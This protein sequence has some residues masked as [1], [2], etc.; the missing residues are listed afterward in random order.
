MQFLSSL[1]TKVRLSG[2]RVEFLVQFTS[3]GCLHSASCFAPRFIPQ[4]GR[5]Y[6]VAIA[7]KQTTCDRFTVLNDE[8]QQKLR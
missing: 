4:R 5:L 7:L 1:S 6:F 2:V 8:E 3:N